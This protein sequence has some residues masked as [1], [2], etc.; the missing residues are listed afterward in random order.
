MAS[1]FQEFQQAAVGF[2]EQSLAIVAP[3]FL[4]ARIA[5][6]F[7][8]PQFL[9]EAPR[10]DLLQNLGINQKELVEKLLGRGGIPSL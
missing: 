10:T 5:R 9:R 2:F 4:K 3:S 7:L 8:L 1:L 6:R